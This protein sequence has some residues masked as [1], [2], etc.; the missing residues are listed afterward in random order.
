MHVDLW[1]RSAFFRIKSQF[2]W[3][4]SH[5]DALEVPPSFIHS[6]QP[7]LQAHLKR[8]QRAP[9]SPM[10]KNYKELTCRDPIS[11]AFF[12]LSHVAKFSTSALS[13]SLSFCLSLSP[14]PSL[15]LSLSP[16]L[17]LSFSSRL[18]QGRAGMP[19]IDIKQTRPIYAV[20]CL[21]CQ[22]YAGSLAVE[23]ERERM[24]MLVPQVPECESRSL[25]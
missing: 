13:L 19:G 21:F 9:P 18:A 15:S 1:C 10:A 12:K 11:S 25:K 14:S 17:F 2:V 22:P 24:S 23:N 7:K 5:F 20:S 6:G 8:S 3:L 4:G 16:S